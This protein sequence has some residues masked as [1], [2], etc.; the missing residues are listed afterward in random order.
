MKSNGNSKIGGI[1]LFPILLIIGIGLLWWN[2]GNYV[3]T[4]SAIKEAKDIYVEVKDGKKETSNDNK[5]IATSGQMVVNDNVTDSTFGITRKTAVLERVVEMYQWDENCDED[6]HCTY[7]SKWADYHLS[8]GSGHTNPEMPY[9]N[10]KFYSSNSVMGDFKLT[11]DNLEFL[12]ANTPY[13]LDAKDAARNNM[14]LV[15]INYLYKGNSM[16]RPEIGDVRVSFNYMNND[17]PVTI[18]VLGLQKG[19]NI[20][21]YVAK[22]GKSIIYAEEGVHSGDEMFQTLTKN[23]KTTTWI[24][25]LIGF[26]LLTI[27]FASIFSPLRFFTDRIP[28]LGNIVSSISGFFSIIAGFAI[29]VIVIAIAWL[30]YRPL[31][32]I[33][34]IA[35]VVGLVFLYLKMKKNKVTPQVQTV[36]SVQSN[37]SIPMNQAEQT[38]QENTIN[39]Q[40]IQQ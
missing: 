37:Q 23:N 19:D 1:I 9:N 22:S 25:R 15:G 16:D 35:A 28:V 32:A 17:Q 27:A 6:N 34:A 12:D 20:T 40:N 13:H 38:S 7:D 2:E 11:K 10:E 33:A 8:G 5:V 24:F 26:V 18:S 36:P 29:S 31:I 39:N 3:K 14:K 4:A 21:K 30:A